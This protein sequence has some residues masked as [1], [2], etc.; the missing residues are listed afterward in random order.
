M[1]R[2]VEPIAFNLGLSYVHL[3]QSQP[4]IPIL[5]AAESA[6]N[7]FQKFGAGRI[8]D[9]KI[10]IQPSVPTQVKSSNDY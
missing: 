10:V 7:L 3:I 9:A 1:E 8:K 5:L 2:L 6:L 4:E